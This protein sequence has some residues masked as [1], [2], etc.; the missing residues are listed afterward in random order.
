MLPIMTQSCNDSFS[1]VFLEQS[2]TAVWVLG[3]PRSWRRRVSGSILELR[4]SVLSYFR[5]SA[6]LHQIKLA[7]KW[8]WFFLSTTCSCQC[9]FIVTKLFGKECSELGWHDNEAFKLLS[10]SWSVSW[11]ESFLVTFHLNLH[12][13]A[14]LLVI[15]PGSSR[16]ASYSAVDQNS[17]HNTTNQTRIFWLGL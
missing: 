16:H 10:L 6:T 5:W 1:L 12:S 14:S 15:N 2:Q 17:G 8:K 9:P 11:D 13:C 3:A 4:R 7:E